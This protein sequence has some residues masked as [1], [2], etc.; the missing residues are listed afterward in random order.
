M[1]VKG[2]ITA[3]GESVRKQG[4]VWKM[5]T[6]FSEIEVGG[7]R[8]QNVVLPDVLENHFKVGDTVEL[9]ILKFY[10]YELTICGIRVNGQMYKCGAVNQLTIGLVLMVLFGWL[11]VTMIP[12]VISLRNYLLIDQF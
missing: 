4:T 7:K 8:I 6:N 12:G 9:L 1:F 2:Q 5:Q 11:I 10:F 3:V